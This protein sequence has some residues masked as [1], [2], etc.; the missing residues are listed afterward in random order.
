MNKPVVH[1]RELCFP[2]VIG[3]SAALYPVDHPSPYVS[4][5]RVAT[6]SAV[7]SYDEAT[8]ELETENTIY[9]PTEAAL[10]SY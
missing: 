6:T 5:T 2:P 7:V 1:Y 4:N 3:E 10:R 8:G 9:M